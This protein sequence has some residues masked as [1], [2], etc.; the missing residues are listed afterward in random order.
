M[1]R[2]KQDHGSTWTPAP[3]YINGRTQDLIHLTVKLGIII[4]YQEHT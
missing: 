1:A 4:R 2:K 3:L